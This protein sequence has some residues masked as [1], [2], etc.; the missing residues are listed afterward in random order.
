MYISEISKLSVQEG[1]AWW[2]IGLMYISSFVQTHNAEAD[3]L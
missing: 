2:Y 3:H 1:N